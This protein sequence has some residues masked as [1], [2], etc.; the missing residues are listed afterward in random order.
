MA[1]A[2]DGMLQKWVQTL[3]SL[4]EDGNCFISQ[5]SLPSLQDSPMTLQNRISI[6]TA[7]IAMDFPDSSTAIL[8]ANA[9]HMSNFLTW[10]TK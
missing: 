6:V 10:I 8:Q 2:T 7:V 4:D 1:T 3:Q 5:E 9:L